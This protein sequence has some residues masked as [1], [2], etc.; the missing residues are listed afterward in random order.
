MLNVKLYLGHILELEKEIYTI[1]RTINNLSSKSNK[2]SIRRA[3]QQPYEIDYD[4]KPEILECFVCG[5]LGLVVGGVIFG[6]LC[7]IYSSCFHGD[8]TWGTIG[9]GALLIGIVVAIVDYPVQKNSIKNKIKYLEEKWEDFYRE[10]DSET[11]RVNKEQP[12]KQIIVKQIATLKSRKEKIE[13]LLKKM[14]DMNILYPKYRNFVA[15]ATIYEYFDSGRCT[16]LEGHEGAYNMYE[17][18]VRLN[19]II[20]KLSD[21]LDDLET[22]KN[23]QIILYKSIKEG[24]NLSKTLCDNTEEIIQQNKEIAENTA[25]TAY[26]SKLIRTEMESINYINLYK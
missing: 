6:I 10:V 22:I 1:N 23:N 20:S 14:Y 26:N 4:E 15:V 16:L 18:E 2:L 19:V 13:D 9:K 11:Y 7:I 5:I 21:I 3:V 24:N 12:Q 25:F 17:N 8:V